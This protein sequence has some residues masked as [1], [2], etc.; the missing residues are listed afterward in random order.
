MTFD[1][2]PLDALGAISLEHLLWA[3]IWVTLDA[4]SRPLAATGATDDTHAMD[5][6]DATENHGQL[7]PDDHRWEAPESHI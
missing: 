5:D 3:I 2:L 6:T 4:Q 7:T 1:L